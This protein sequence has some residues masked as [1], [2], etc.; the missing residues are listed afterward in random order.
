MSA[1]P[2]RLA[3]GSVWNRWDPHI[4][5]PRTVLNDQ[6]GG[7]EAWEEFL[8]RIETSYP[9]VRA[10]GIT[11]YYSIESYEAV[12]ERKRYGRLPEV[13]LIFPNIEMRYGIG[14]GKGS[15]INVH[16]L[17]S[18]EDPDHLE[19][20]RRFLRSLTFNAF[21]ESFRC[22]RSDLIRLGCAYDKN[23]KDAAPALAAGANQFKINPDQLRD[24]WT[25][26]TWV[27]ENVLV[28][29]A[30]GSK[31]GTSG[32]QGD[33]SLA[34]LRKEI[35]RF[36][37]IIFSSQP[38]QRKFW[39]GQGAATPAQLK[40]DWG[41]FKPCLHGSDAH[42]PEAVATP[43]LDRY[44]WI[45]GDLAFES[46]RQ[47]CLEPETRAFIGSVPPRGALPSQ[48]IS[49]VSVTNAPW[50]K[51]GKVSLNP[52]LVAI[53]GARGSG[54]T[55][56][57]DVIAA[58]GFALSAHLSERSFIRRASAHLGDSAAVLTWEAGDP[59]SNEF[60]HAEIEELLDSSRVRYLS[61]QFVDTLCSA[62]GLTD[63]LLS[64]IERVIYQ[65]HQPE[66]RMGTT[67]FR[68]L[69]QVRTARGRSMRQ[70]H[71]EALLEAN[72]YITAERERRANLK[73]LQRQREEKATSIDKD[74]R[75][76]STLIGA[77]AE[78]RTKRL[79]EV[80][81]A[82]EA[83]RF[84]VEQTRRQHQALLALKDEV[85][86]TRKS[87]APIYLQRLQEAHRETGLSPETWKLFLLDFVGDVDTILTDA[88]KTIADR[89]RALSGPAPNEVV[90]SPNAPPS[91]TPFLPADAN[92]SKQTLTLL[93][94][95]VAR[96]RKLIGIDA[97]KTRAFAR[98]TEKISREEAALAKLVKLKLLAA[99]IRRS[100][101]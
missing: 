2:A 57:A 80:S 94:K 17:V 56:L 30:A 60:R 12:L 39:L 23:I 22:E 29:V 5:T 81:T 42:G 70:R 98:L 19:Q 85:S 90:V 96:L 41:G 45:K 86:D 84:H 91:S 76:R 65:A 61:Q 7:E 99:P 47:A 64:E 59:T 93:D 95:E 16:L 44:C 54:K 11:D 58:G 43:D 15:P 74:K 79:D 87:K 75:D 100:K 13:D 25:R 1:S 72:T 68:E 51:N 101:N 35:E 55:A 89:I 40:A 73:S 36:T 33:P 82:A 21:G 78:E 66:N 69:L 14:T 71:E 6:Y 52:G 37:H 8:R 92:L 20:V 24:E 62:E 32:L 3:I 53:I 31:D 10:L 34:T 83:V 50:L 48:V 63:E 38:T 97:E 27:Q 26:S 88:V 9:R 18:P 28:A 4:H 49:A 77:G 67:S 46:L